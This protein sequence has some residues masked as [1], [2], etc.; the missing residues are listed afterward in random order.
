[1]S[2]RL[3]D[4]TMQGSVIV[5]IIP[6][7]LNSARSH[8]GCLSP[9]PSPSL[10]S[11]NLA[12]LC[13]TPTPCHPTRSLLSR[14][15]P[16]HPRPEPRRSPCFGETRAC[17]PPGSSS[18]CMGTLRCAG[19]TGACQRCRCQ[20]LSRRA[21]FPRGRGATALMTEDPMATPHRSSLVQR[22]SLR[23]C[24]RPRT[25]YAQRGGPRRDRRPVGW[26]SNVS[27]A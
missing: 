15:D 18:G 6:G 17:H 4:A 24:R 8:S 1:M 16:F 27:S 25:A 26:C 19:A 9:P 23:R 3:L 12:L 7:P 11:M 22:G 20:G 5:M 2:P 13:R 21:R 14:S 10:T